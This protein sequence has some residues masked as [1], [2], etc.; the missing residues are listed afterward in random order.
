MRQK[1]RV[2]KPIRCNS[3]TSASLCKGFAGLDLVPP[4]VAITVAALEKH[5]DLNTDL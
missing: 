1:E 2:A 5:R 4:H 3:C